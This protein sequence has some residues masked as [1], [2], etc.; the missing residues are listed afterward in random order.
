MFSCYNEKC[1]FENDRVRDFSTGSHTRIKYVFY[2][3]QY[4]ECGL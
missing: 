1:G 2:L 4:F 3:F